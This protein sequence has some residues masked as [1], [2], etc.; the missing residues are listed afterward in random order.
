MPISRR[1][2]TD[3]LRRTRIIATIGPASAEERTIEALLEAGV[4][5]FRLN[6]SHGDA[7]WHRRVARRVR[8]AAKALGQHAAI[9]ADLSGPKM[10]T[11]RFADGSIELA[12][13]ARVVVTTERVEG[14]TGVIPSQYRALP[15]DVRSGQPILLDDGRLELSV[16][17]VRGSEVRC[18]VVR[19]G[20]LSD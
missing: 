3:V 20:T 12:T 13:D 10:R 8:R 15:R 9:L 6:F 5:V 14:S 1:S 17:A 18:R 4:D 16:E 19:G 2:R 7:V 11:G